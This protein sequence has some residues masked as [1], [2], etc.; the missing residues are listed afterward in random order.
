MPKNKE[1]FV[2]C[3]NCKTRFIRP[4]VVKEKCGVCGDGKERMFKQVK[5]Y[6]KISNKNLGGEAK[7]ASSRSKKTVRNKRKVAQKV[8]KV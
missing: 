4:K 1:I 2:E 6:E 7:G 5:G 3:P 8:S